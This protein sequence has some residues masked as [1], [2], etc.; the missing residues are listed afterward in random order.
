MKLPVATVG[1]SLRYGV[2]AVIALA[3]ASQIAAAQQTVP[4]LGRITVQPGEGFLISP[5]TGRN[6]GTGTN[7]LDAAR[8]AGIENPTGTPQTQQTDRKSTRLNSSH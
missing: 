5:Q 8:N 7:P 1:R 6:G 4:G 2:V 3:S